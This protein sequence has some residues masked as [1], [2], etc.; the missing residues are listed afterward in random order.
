MDRGMKMCL[1]SLQRS[2]QQTKQKDKKKRKRTTQEGSESGTVSRDSSHESASSSAAP[3]STFYSVSAPSSSSTCA[4]TSIRHTT[5]LATYTTP[6]YIYAARPRLELCC[7]PSR[8]NPTGYSDGLCQVA[9]WLLKHS[10]MLAQKR[11][12]DQHALREG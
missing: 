6:L 1:R 5:L 4:L 10:G 8:T 12:K 9:D 2:P 11:C 7:G 3:T